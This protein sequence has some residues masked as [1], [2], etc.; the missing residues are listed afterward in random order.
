MRNSSDDGTLRRFSLLCGA[1]KKAVKEKFSAMRNSLCLDK[2]PAS[3]RCLFFRSVNVLGCETGPHGCW[4]RP[5]SRNNRQ[6]LCV[7]VSMTGESAIHQ[8]DDRG[9]TDIVSWLARVPDKTAAMTLPTCKAHQII[10]ST[11]RKLISERHC[12]WDYHRAVIVIVCRHQNNLEITR[13]SENLCDEEIARFLPRDDDDWENFPFL[14]AIRELLRSL[15][16]VRLTWLTRTFRISTDSTR[17]MR[18]CRL[19]LKPSLADW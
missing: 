10:V 6:N 13:K 19:R 16:R 7:G 9:K 15:F 14:R 1:R 2:A 17:L 18:T 3:I 11:E 8:H 4:A 12:R 5:G